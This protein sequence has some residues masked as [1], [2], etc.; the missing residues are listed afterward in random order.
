MQLKYDCLIIMKY[1]KDLKKYH[2]EFLLKVE[3]FNVLSLSLLP[4]WNTQLPRTSSYVQLAGVS[5]YT[6]A[7]P[8]KTTRYTYLSMFSNNF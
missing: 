3:Q 2:L 4:I 1:L 5:A 6:L 7:M 8:S